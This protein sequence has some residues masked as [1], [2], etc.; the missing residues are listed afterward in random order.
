MS[1]EAA[2]RCRHG[3]RTAGRSRRN[4]TTRRQS[5][6]DRSIASA[7]SANSVRGCMGGARL[8]ADH[9]HHGAGSRDSVRFHGANTLLVGDHLLMSR[10]GYDV[11]RAV[12]ALPSASLARAAPPAD[13]NFSRA[14]SRPRPGLHQTAHRPARRRRGNSQGVVLTSTARRSAEPYRNGPPNPTDNY[15]PVTVPPR[16]TTLFSAIIATIPLTAATGATCPNPIILGTPVFI[17]MSVEAPDDAWQP[18]QSSRT[19]PGLL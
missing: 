8:P 3:R 6:T 18:G 10:I 2:R 9:R 14:D 4:W 19:P 17:Y 15:G 11:Q 7:F 16:K 13:D 1:A 5:I 12:H